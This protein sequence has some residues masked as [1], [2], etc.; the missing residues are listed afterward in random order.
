MDL[1]AIIKRTTNILIR[2]AEEWVVIEKENTSKGNVLSGYALPYIIAI[3][4]ASAIG[5]M[6]FSLGLYSVPYVIASTLASVIVP[7]AG[8][9]ISSYI[10]NAL[11]PAFGS[12]PNLDNAF[13]LV[14]YS[15][16]A[17]FIVSIVTG[18]VPLL[19]FLSI[20]GL[21]SMY[22][23]WTGFG[24]MMKTPD[25][26]KAGYAI[27]SILIILGIYSILAIVFAFIVATMFLSGVAHLVF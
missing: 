6:V 5:S 27:V 10:I 9:Y 13:K 3:A 4:L 7:V 22:I 12:K 14:V 17:S 23:L 19:V 24:P 15:Y 21:Y 16:T 2:P 8:I 25:E 20:A 26:K 18:L 1:N 11:A